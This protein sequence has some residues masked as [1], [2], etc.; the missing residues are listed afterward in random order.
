MEHKKDIGNRI[1]FARE[2]K[3]LQQKYVAKLL[4]VHFSTL[5]KME[6]G[7]HEPDSEKIRVMSDIFEV[8]PEWILY[9]EEK[10]STNKKLTE[11]ELEVLTLFNQLSNEGKEWLLKTIKMVKR[12]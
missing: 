10:Q 5:S 8:T 9:G 2:R 11:S 12:I 7:F 4:G 6:L 1:R 3:G